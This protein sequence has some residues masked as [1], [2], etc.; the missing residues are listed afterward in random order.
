MEFL[1]IQSLPIIT[2]TGLFVGM[3]FALDAGTPSL[4][5]ILLG[6]FVLG[7]LAAMLVK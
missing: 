6:L 3:V 2:L 5:W 7:N 1:G 4:V